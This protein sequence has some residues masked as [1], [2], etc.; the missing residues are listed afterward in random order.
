MQVQAEISA[1]RAEAQIGTV[2]EVII[3]GPGE[4]DSAYLA[5]SKAD[6]PEIDGVVHV[7]SPA[8]LG[9][10]DIVPVRI[11]DADDYDLWAEHT[12]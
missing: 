3:D 4:T 12:A 7:D 5:R 9:A 6:A 11:T 2:Q 8:C 10:G 1:A